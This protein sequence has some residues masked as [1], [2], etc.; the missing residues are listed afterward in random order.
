MILTRFPLTSIA[1][2]ALATG[3]LLVV[4]SV[5][6]FGFFGGGGVTELSQRSAALPQPQAQVRVEAPVLPLNLLLTNDSEGA[7]Q[8][9]P[10]APA[11][12]EW[13][14]TTR[15]VLLWSASADDA[16][17]FTDAPEGTILRL[18]GQTQSGR[19]MVSYAGDGLFRKPGTAWVDAT[20]VA[21]TDA[22]A[23]LSAINDMAF[24]GLSDWMVT[25]RV[26]ALW[27]G[28]DQKAVSLVELPKGAYV[29]AQGP[30]RDGRALV[31][32][33]GD[34]GARQ[35]GVGWVEQAATATSAAPGRWLQ[36]KVV[37]SLYSGS[38]DR[39]SRF[40]DLPARSLVKIVEA[41]AASD[42]RIQVEY[43]GDG[44]T[45]LPGV[46]W[47]PKADLASVTAPSPL[48]TR[49]APTSPNVSA[50]RPSTPSTMTPI[51]PYTVKNNADFI[52]QVGTAAQRSMKITNV[53][54]SV[55]VAQAILE[56]DWGRSGLSRK[57]N[58]LFGIKATRVVGSAGYIVMPTWENVDGED[59]TVN[60][61]F[62]AYATLEDSVTDHGKLFQQSNFRK[63]MAVASDPRSF[64]Q[65]IADAGYATDP[66]YASKLIAIMDRYNLYQFD[67]R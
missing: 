41:S 5:P 18:L 47:A 65:A 3:G 63:A 12:P 25:Q 52:A 66:A 32:Y 11:S 31:S 1:T 39:A 26:V 16:K 15:A 28:P 27:S 4:L 53:P 21:G 40:T 54:A 58:N 49:P 64:A 2:G 19:V 50:A 44:G 55:T 43:F 13:V 30:V 17:I 51:Q 56:S 29:Q 57:A 38:D 24:K 61:S 60:Q 9:G 46:A 36:A 62:R 20:S 37:S 42:K 10:A 67:A 22:P 7:S 14:R 59:V 34:F 33:E 45:R 6:A 23:D 48:P 8:I 35:P